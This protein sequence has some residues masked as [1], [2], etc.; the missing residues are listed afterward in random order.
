MVNRL[1]WLERGEKLPVQKGKCRL[2][3][4]PLPKRRRGYCSDECRDRYLCATSTE[5]LRYKVFERDGGACVYCETDCNQLE[6]RVFGFSMM[7]KKPR[8]RFEKDA[9]MLRHEERAAKVQAL[10]DNGW[11]KLSAHPRSLWEAEHRIALADGGSFDLNNVDTCC[12]MC[13]TAKSS[14]E[15]T[16]RAKRKRLIGKRQA[17]TMR[18]FKKMG[19]T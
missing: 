17:D 6:I 15:A 13:H 14:R 2:C 10:M 8:Y 5:F 19:I 11:P 18:R 4:E 9:L 12:L 1:A 16:A 3:L 7:S